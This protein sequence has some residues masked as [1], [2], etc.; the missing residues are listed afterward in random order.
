MPALVPTSELAGLPAAQRDAKIIALCDQAI[1]QLREARDL[2]EVFGIRNAAEAFAVYSRKYKSAVDAQAQCQ[3]VVLLAE[4][5][6]GTELAA[7]QARGEVAKADGVVNQHSKEGARSAGTLPATLSDL[8]IPSQR[9]ADMKA[10][11]KKGEPAIRA[12]VKAAADSGRVASRR[13]ILR[14]ISAITERPPECTQFILWLRTG[15]QLL[16]RLGDPSSL[17]PTLAQH[18]LL[19]EPGQVETIMSFLSRLEPAE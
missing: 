10:L 8:N 16:A 4:V 9:A 1:D 14:G 13:S 17:L 12:H 19:P 5:R 7:A 11:A 6:I 2:E 3:L 18:R 15:T